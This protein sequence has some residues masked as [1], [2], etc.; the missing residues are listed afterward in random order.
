MIETL[1]NINIVTPALR[2]IITAAEI[3]LT[4]FALYWLW[5]IGLKLFSLFGKRIVK[6]AP[7]R[8]ETTTAYIPEVSASRKSIAG[9]GSESGFTPNP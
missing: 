1:A 7:A 5:E 8:P 2:G 4:G 6:S 3:L 9:V